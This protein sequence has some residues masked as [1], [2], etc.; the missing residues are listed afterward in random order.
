MKRLD[1]TDLSLLSKS[2]VALLRALLLRRGPEGPEFEAELSWLAK[3]AGLKLDTAKRALKRLRDIGC[4]TTKRAIAFIQLGSAG[5]RRRASMNRY[6]ILG[7]IRVSKGIESISIPKVGFMEWAETRNKRGRPRKGSHLFLPEERKKNPPRP[8]KTGKTQ[9]ESFA[10][11]ANDSVVF[12]LKESTSNCS[13]RTGLPYVSPK[14]I[15]RK[16]SA[17]ARLGTVPSSSPLGKMTSMSVIKLDG[18]HPLRV[19]RRRS[20]GTK[21]EK[22]SGANLQC[23]SSEPDFGALLANPSAS[24]PLPLPKEMR[25]PWIPIPDQP[26]QEFIGQAKLDSDLSERQQVTVMVQAFNDAHLE[27]FKKHGHAFRRSGSVL[28]SKVYPL[29]R[30][31]AAALIEK[32]IAPQAWCE[33]R[34]AYYKDNNKTCPPMQVILSS[35]TILTK[36]GWFRKDYDRPDQHKLIFTR[37]NYEQLF[38][39]REAHRYN[40]GCKNPLLA[41]PRWYVEMRQIEIEKGIHSPIQFYPRLRASG[42]SGGAYLSTV[43]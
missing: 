26:Q 25:I 33:W 13:V 10:K 1:G 30:T 34:M 20:R 12:S 15:L 14:E 11:K 18:R 19:L 42:G 16:D 37:L 35:K 24:T 7:S 28:R 40:R 9:V 32:G 43:S 27:I 8:P 29:L 4:V 2:T 17:S 23:T 3:K 21:P 22:I 31:A 36:S 39:S 5:H 38:R 41:L 6:T